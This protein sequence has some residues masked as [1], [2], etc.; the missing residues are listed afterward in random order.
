MGKTLSATG[1]KLIQSF[2]GLRLVAYPDPGSADGSGEPYT[3]GWGHCGGVR[4]GDSVAPAEATQM[5]L[6]DVASAEDAVNELAVPISQNV[7]D[8]LV[9]FTFNVGVGNLQTSSLWRRLSA[10]E[11][12]VEVLSQELPR[13]NKGGSG[14]L[15]GL[16]RRRLAEIELARE[17]EPAAAEVVPAPPV[18]IVHPPEAPIR[19]TP[20]SAVKAPAAAPLI[21]LREAAKYS[22]GLSWQDKAWDRLQSSLSNE[23]LEAF[24][25]DFRATPAAVAAK[26]S[27][28]MPAALQLEVPYLFQ[29]DSHTPSG[30]RM[31][32]SSTCAML[33]EFLH[34]GSLTGDQPDDLYLEVV[35]RFGGSEEAGAQIKALATFG[36]VAQFRQDGT[37]ADLYEQLSGGIPCPVGWLHR[38]GAKSPSGNGH[39][40]LVVGYDQPGKFFIHHDPNGEAALVEGGFVSN[41]PTSGRFV[42]YSAKNWGPRWMAEGKG[43]GWWIKVLSH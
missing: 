39:W 20:A 18:E 6:Q 31:C 5:L 17:C 25:H 26:P 42:H 37:L 13:W 29:L 35:E 27:S 30:W 32:F 14:V 12:P 7:F 9:S 15:A 16:V 41:E 33:V 19:A 24:A 38:G 3:I 10:A 34:P 22:L 28:A 43:S 21:S 1:L 2:E 36:I 23:Q 40:T 4:P 8:A 11:D